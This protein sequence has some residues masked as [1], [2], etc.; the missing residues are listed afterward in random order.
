MGCEVAYASRTVYA[1]GVD[2]DDVE[3]ADPIGPGCRACERTDC[4]HRAL[5]PIGRRLDAGA[6]E[7]GLVRYRIEAGPG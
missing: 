3:A 1:K 5:P 2:L 6:A 4:G 7:R